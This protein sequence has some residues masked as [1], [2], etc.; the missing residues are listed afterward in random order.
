MGP[1]RG[2]ARPPTASA[3]LPWPAPGGTAT[4]EG[5][6]PYRDAVAAE[7][8]TAPIAD[9]TLE[10]VVEPRAV[11]LRHRRGGVRLAG[12]EIVV[13][14]QGR[15]APQHRR[16]ELE[17]GALRVTRGYPGRELA[18]WLEIRPGVVERVWS[19]QPR[20]LLDDG[21]LEAARALDRLAARL[22][23][24]TGDR[25][26]PATELGHG[27]HRVLL[28]DHGDRLV[29]YARPLF[30]ERP[31]RC[32]EVCS[33]GTLVVP[34]RGGDRRARFRSRFDVVAG[35]D[36]IRFAGESGDDVAQLYLPW[37]SPEDRAELA[38]RCAEL[39]DPVPPDQS[40]ASPLA[41]PAGAA[42]TPRLAAGWPLPLSR[43]R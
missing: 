41:R 9:G 29:V 4:L 12:R 14:R 30:R 17:P 7:R 18:L 38:R 24:A 25:G 32:F 2:P 16:L 27:G 35:G 34:G 5:M 42:M 11:E 22:V 8:L 37:I 23:E 21:G 31:R 6:A 19:A 28:A 40:R 15:R 26:G 10:L 33:D 36:R 20:S 1:G 43:V 39:V 13:T 3:R